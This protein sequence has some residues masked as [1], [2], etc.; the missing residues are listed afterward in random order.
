M[1]YG[2]FELKWEGIMIKLNS[3]KFLDLLLVL[4]LA[5]T[6]FSIG[7]DL[8]TGDPVCPSIFTPIPEGG[9]SDQILWDLTHGVYLNY[10][11]AGYYSSLTAALFAEGFDMETTDLGVNNIDLS[12]YEVIV[13]CVGS[14]WDSQYQPAEV[15]AIVDFVNGGGGLLI[16]ADASG[17][18]NEN[19]LPVSI[20]FGTTVDLNTSE[21]SD[22]Y[23]TNFISHRIFDNSTTIYYRAAGA[24]TCVPPSV[25]AA[26]SPIYSDVMVSLVDP[27]P[28]IVVMSDCNCFSNSY[29]SIEDN[30]AFSIDVFH[31]LAG[32]GVSLQHDTWG[33]IKAAANW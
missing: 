9:R 21:P 5:S 7:I 33:A 2:H 32:H 24:V 10:E 27:S 22:L 20:A 14:S 29:Y 30:T 25:E 1:L 17:C 26:W 4:A 31:Y 12:P 13:I 11:P 15:T 16:I 23:F 8:T 18:P 6:A 19:I 28:R 3:V